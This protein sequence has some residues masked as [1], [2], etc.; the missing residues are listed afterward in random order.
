M[1][2]H[3]LCAIDLDSFEQR[4]VDLAASF[5]RTMSAE[6]DIAYVTTVPEI[7]GAQHT[8]YSRSLPDIL[9]NERRLRSVRPA[10]GGIQVNH[11]H[12]LGMPRDELLRLI[13]ESSPRLV[14]VGTH[15]RHGLTRWLL[16][17]VAEHLLRHA[18]CPVVIVRQSQTAGLTEK[19][20]IQ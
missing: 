19:T 1:N 11:H 14:V 3:V 17:S 9:S 4:I 16:G 18:P 10:D 7:N 2:S 6:L 20:R 5:A 15:G 12:L 8:S 13:E